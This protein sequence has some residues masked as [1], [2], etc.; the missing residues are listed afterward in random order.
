MAIRP[1]FHLALAG[2]KS[3]ILHLEQ[4]CSAVSDSEDKLTDL[5]ADPSPAHTDA[6]EAQESA[7]AGMDKAERILYGL[8]PENGQELSALIVAVIESKGPF[9]KLTALMAIEC[10]PIYLGAQAILSA[11]EGR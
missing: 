1:E 6:L 5:T 9:N 3:A 7:H 4:A 10:A 2:F 8:T 11:A